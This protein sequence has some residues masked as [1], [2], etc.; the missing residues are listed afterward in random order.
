MLCFTSSTWLAVLR[1]GEMCPVP[2]AVLPGRFW[3]SAAVCSPGSCPFPSL[4]KVKSC[5]QCYCGASDVFQISSLHSNSPHKASFLLPPLKS[6]TKTERGGK[7]R[8][9]TFVFL[10][11]ESNAPKTGRRLS[12]ITREVQHFTK[13]FLVS[14]GGS[15]QELSTSR[16]QT[17]HGHAAAR[18]PRRLC[19]RWHLL[20]SS[21]CLGKGS[22]VTVVIITVSL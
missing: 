7:S 4:L 9:R 15:P 3:S 14:R 11:F 8:S 17:G 6:R 20:C 5:T 12:F 13:Q 16:E 10:A 18:T 2:W 21:L 22:S 19:G 1:L